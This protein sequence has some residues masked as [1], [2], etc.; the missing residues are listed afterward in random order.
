MSADPLR[1]AAQQRH[2]SAT[3]RAKQALRDLDHEGAPISFRGVA[4][5]AGVSRQWLYTQP[6]LRE[7][8]GRL[9]EEGAGTTAPL[10]PNHQRAGEASLRQR[11]ALL[12]A[13]NRRLRDELAELRDELAILHGERRETRSR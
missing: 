9:R 11:N 10:V 7:E 3:G 1:A 12:L 4:L 13:E 2:D 6:C 5:R 8:I